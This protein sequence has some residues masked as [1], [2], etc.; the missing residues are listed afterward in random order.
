MNSGK[1]NE[2]LKGQGAKADRILHSLYA[3]EN[4]FYN[5]SCINLTD[6]VYYTN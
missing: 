1:I 2:I 6:Y 4:L 5:I 3:D